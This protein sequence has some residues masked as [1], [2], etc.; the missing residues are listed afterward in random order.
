MFPT[1]FRY[2]RCVVVDQRFAGLIRS[3]AHIEVLS[4]FTCQFAL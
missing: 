4:S 3:D 1:G 2:L